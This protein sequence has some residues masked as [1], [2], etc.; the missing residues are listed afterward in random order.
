MNSDLASKRRF[1]LVLGLLTGIAAV[2]V[3]LSLPAFPEMVRE[4]A[5]SMSAGQRVVGLFMA[6]IA[7]G[8]IPA[9][10]ISD[11]VGR[12]PV[13]YGGIVI[14]TIAG[15]VCA[16]TDSIE[17]MLVSRFIQGLG[18]SV[19]IVVTRAIVR[20]ISS[21]AQAARLM[22]VMVMIFTAA[23]MLAPLVGAYL[24]YWWGW[25]APFAAVVLFGA[26][27][28][29]GVNMA[30]QETHSPSRKEHPVRQLSLSLK[31][32]FSHRRSRFGL[33]L[34]ILPAA[35]FLAMITGSSAIIIEVYGFPVQ[36][37][38]YLF[39]CSGL[40]ILTGSTLSRHIVLEHGVIRVIGLGAAMIGFAS[41]QLLTIAWLGDASFWWLWGCVCL[42]MLGVGLLM[43]N[44][45]AL[46][47]DPVPQ[48]AGVASS[49]IGTLQSL[50]GAVGSLASSAVYDGSVRN[51]AIIM[52]A[53]GLAT[54]IVFLLRPLFLGLEEVVGPDH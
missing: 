5:T 50:A 47:L 10:L 22:S 26:M 1:V 14:F 24:V 34:V 9:G 48:I 27:I 37:F 28:L 12:I 46:A 2:T 32:F 16:A 7:V 17:L 21:G 51:V 40:S 43:P 45:T 42:F 3:D 39:A 49:I 18:G 11:R 35:G 44:A 6:G 36:Y 29:L 31:E 25:R 33:S 41:L 13:L 38:G 23:P 52:G 54:A 19:G 15:I 53:C 20:D 30:L 8:Q 4:L